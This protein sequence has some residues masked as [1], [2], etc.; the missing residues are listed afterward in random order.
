MH[1]EKCAKQCALELPNSSK[2]PA[3]FL[4]V[5]WSAYHC[6]SVDLICI[7]DLE[8]L[9]ALF[10][11][12]GLIEWCRWSKHHSNNLSQVAKADFQMY[13]LCFVFISWHWNFSRMVCLLC[14]TASQDST[15]FWSHGWHC[16]NTHYRF[17]ADKMKIFRGESCWLAE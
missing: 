15:L 10:N 7:L 17:S 2:Q 9:S 1:V 5:S 13:L 4:P 6:V 12:L 16:V 11:N 14:N 8:N 3:V